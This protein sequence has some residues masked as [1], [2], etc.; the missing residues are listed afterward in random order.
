MEKKNPQWN[1]GVQDF[2]PSR[3]FSKLD[4]V[5]EWRFLSH[6]RM[7]VWNEREITD[8]ANE[9]KWKKPQTFKTQKGLGWKGP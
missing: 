1:A 7:M 3:N 8:Q 4:T 9:I 6:R 2:S 5:K